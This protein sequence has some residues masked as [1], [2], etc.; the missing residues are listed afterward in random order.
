MG[1]VEPSARSNGGF[2]LYT[3]DDIARLRWVA[4]LKPMRF[5][6]EQIRELLDLKAGAESGT[7]SDADR[8]R[9]E[10]FALAAEA[11]ARTLRE[12][13]G[14]ATDTAAELR[15]AA[16]HRDG[17]SRQRRRDRVVGTKSHTTASAPSGPAVQ[18]IS[19]SPRRPRSATQVRR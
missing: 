9:L 5:T 12:Q 13:L 19:G 3:A 17:T 18:A 2:R 11:S 16:A 8:S 10:F 15:A 4:R 14:W 6:L 1:V 7:L